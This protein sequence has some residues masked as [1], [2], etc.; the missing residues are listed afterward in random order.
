MQKQSQNLP[1]SNADDL[2]EGAMSKTCWAPTDVALLV[3]R[4]GPGSTGCC[5]CRLRRGTAASCSVILV[6]ATSYN[7][8]ALLFFLSY[9]FL[10]RVQDRVF[11]SDIFSLS[12]CHS[13]TCAGV[14][15]TGSES[16]CKKLQKTKGLG[17]RI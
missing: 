16:H 13:M 17:R 10:E 12:E 15:L 2:L 9:D 8:A 6:M 1:F 5:I 4:G 14:A 11:L 7:M 3:S